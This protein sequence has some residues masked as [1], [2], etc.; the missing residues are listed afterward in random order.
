MESAPS[1]AHARGSPPPDLPRRNRHDDEDD[2]SARP[3]S[4]RRRLEGQAPFGHWATQ[5]FIA[6]LRCDGLTAPWVVD[7]PMDREIFD[8]YIETQL[9]P[10]LQPGDVVILDNLGSHKS[11]KAEAIL[12]QRGGWFL[13]LP[14]YSPDL[15]PSKWRSPSLRPI[16]GALAREPSMPAG[17]LSATS[18]P[19]LPTKSAGT[20]SKT[21]ATRPIKRSA[22]WRPN[23][24]SESDLTLAGILSRL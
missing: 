2:P 3:R 6:G 10:T 7:K 8:T 19:S 18:A 4:L 15:I 5:T 21:Q 11:E 17:K 16:S 1:A 23:R 9:A 14:P 22:L 24:S 20:T 12:K 13:F